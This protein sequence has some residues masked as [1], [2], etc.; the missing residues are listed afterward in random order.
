MT[1]KE[2]IERDYIISKVKFDGWKINLWNQKYCNVSFHYD[3]ND[4]YEAN[5]VYF[6]KENVGCVI[7][8]VHLHKDNKLYI[9]YTESI[10]DGIFKFIDE[11]L[12]VEPMGMLKLYTYYEI[13]DRYKKNFFESMSNR[14][15]EFMSE[16]NQY[17][18]TYL[19]LNKVS[20]DTKY[21]NKRLR[22]PDMVVLVYEKNSQKYLDRIKAKVIKYEGFS[23]A[24]EDIYIT[25]NTLYNISVIEPQTAND[26]EISYFSTLSNRN[27]FTYTGDNRYNIKYNSNINT[28]FLEDNDIDLSKYIDFINFIEGVPQTKKSTKAE[29]K[30]P[31]QKK[32][33]AKPSKEKQTTTKKSEQKEP[34][35]PTKPSSNQFLDE[36]VDE[37]DKSIEEAEKEE[38]F[39]DIDSSE[40][41]VDEFEKSIEEEEQEVFH[42]FDYSEQ[43]S[44]NPSDNEN[45]QEGYDPREQLQ[46][47]PFDHEIITDAKKMYNN[48][49]NI[50]EIFDY[51]NNNIIRLL[52]NSSKKES[53]IITKNNLPAQNLYQFSMEYTEDQRIV[54]KKYS[55]KISV[56]FYGHDDYKDPYYN[57]EIYTSDK[58][59]FDLKNQDATMISFIENN[60]S[61]EGRIVFKRNQSILC[62]GNY[63][64]EPTNN[65]KYNIIMTINFRGNDKFHFK[66]LLKSYNK[67]WIPHQLIFDNY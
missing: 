6:L 25:H 67:K 36:P 27:I 55:V 58:I 39:Y 63:H 2:D 60:F 28:D 26:D 41:P 45:D 62:I 38:V 15:K 57:F 59:L 13:S 24:P 49:T 35:P 11:N 46:N 18:G 14:I 10:D 43:E 1:N 65:N 9:S 23:V 53:P 61:Q 34:N 32:E 22:N 51:I 56:L 31:E 30:T 4:E 66:F 3:T 54:G 64:L 29:K 37:F 17:Y 50:D 20:F 48:G 44:E 40:Q 42:D 52:K 12:K 21:E 33:T 47:K 8:G 7:R 5:L 19:Q 16:W